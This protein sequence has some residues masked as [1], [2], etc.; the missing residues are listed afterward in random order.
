[1]LQDSQT[2]S[3]KTLRL[4]LQG[5]RGVAVIVVFFAHAGVIGFSGGYIGVDLFFVLSG[6]LITG[7][8]YK[9]YEANGKLN[10]LG[11]Y[12][13]RLKRLLPA[14]V[15]VITLTL[16]ASFI[17]LPSFQAKAQIGSAPFHHY[18]FRISTSLFLSSIISMNLGKMT[19]FCIRGLWGSKSSF[20]WFGRFCFC[21]LPGF[22]NEEF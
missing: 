4:D 22:S 19:C 13:R 12:S 7:V 5:L 1:M 6:F 15:L 10:V 21:F 3:S 2:R 8:L 14:M 18:G 16:V 17:L 9:E 20:I 11:F